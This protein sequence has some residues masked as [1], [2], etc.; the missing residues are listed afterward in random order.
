MVWTNKSEESPP[1]QGTSGGICLLVC[2]YIQLNPW[3]KPPDQKIGPTFQGLLGGCRNV[4]VF[5]YKN[6]VTE[7]QD[8][9]VVNFVLPYITSEA[10]LVVSL[11]KAKAAT[12]SFH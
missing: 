1:F 3:S 7:L 6:G 11:V 9:F 12:E 8:Q 5:P 10:P 4:V 2:G